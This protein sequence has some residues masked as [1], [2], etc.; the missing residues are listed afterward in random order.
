MIVSFLSDREATSWPLVVSPLNRMAAPRLLSQ[1]GG[2]PVEIPKNL[3]TSRNDASIR[4]YGT[5]NQTTFERKQLKFLVQF[6]IREGYQ[7]Q[8]SEI[9]QLSLLLATWLG[10]LPLNDEIP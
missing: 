1:K 8:Q 10:A 6:P 3:T 7:N 9:I 2:C 5:R 4:G